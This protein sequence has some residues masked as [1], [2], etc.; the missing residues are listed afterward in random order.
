MHVWSFCAA[1]Q[2]AGRAELQRGRHLGDAGLCSRFMGVGFRKAPSLNSMSLTKCEF[3][4]S[5]IVR[6]ADASPRTGELPRDV[7]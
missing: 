1:E 3:R 6:R 5:G 2:D 7:A 4:P